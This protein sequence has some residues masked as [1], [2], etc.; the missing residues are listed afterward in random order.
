MRSPPRINVGIFNILLKNWL[1]GIQA[2]FERF[3]IRA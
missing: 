2:S 1:L 3:K